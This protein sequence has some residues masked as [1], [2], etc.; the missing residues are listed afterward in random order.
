MIEKEYIEVS[1]L[2]KLR[3]IKS[4]LSDISP[5][6]IMSRIEISGI[7][8]NVWQYIREYEKSLNIDREE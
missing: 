8:H 3:T 1:N 2:D 7:N 4:M 6:G 5:D